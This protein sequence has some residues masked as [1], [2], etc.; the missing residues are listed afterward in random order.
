MEEMA[1]A[2]EEGLRALRER[3]SHEEF[4]EMVRRKREAMEALAQGRQ[5]MRPLSQEWIRCRTEQGLSDQAVESCLARCRDAFDRIRASEDEI[6]G[7]ATAYLARVASES[8]SVEDRIRLH[9]TWS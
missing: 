3:F 5:A 7:M 1:Q 9:R 2:Q 4:L 6:E 8:G